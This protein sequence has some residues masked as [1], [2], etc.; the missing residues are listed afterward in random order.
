[1]VSRSMMQVALAVREF[2]F[3]RQKLQTKIAK[4]GIVHWARPATIPVK[5]SLGFCDWLVVDACMT[6]ADKSLLIELQVFVS[7]TAEP[8]PR[9]VPILISEP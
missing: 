1:M 6:T 4:A 9:I 3:D 5:V 2:I 8:V 7:I